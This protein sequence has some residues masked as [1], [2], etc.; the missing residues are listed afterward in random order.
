MNNF[1]EYFSNFNN[2]KV[3]FLNNIEN[4]KKSYPLYKVFP[5][6]NTYKNEYL[7]DINNLENIKSDIFTSIIELLQE[8]MSLSNVVK[9]L[10]RDLIELENKNN[11]LKIKNNNLKNKMN[12]SSGELKNVKEKN[13]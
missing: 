3:N 13:I 8:N 12:A 4:I 9:N 11:N 2:L 1:D 7:L 5:N 6:N 10:N